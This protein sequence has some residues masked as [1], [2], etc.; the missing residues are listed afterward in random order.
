M[1]LGRITDASIAAVRENA[2]IDRVVA[3]YVTLKKA[4]AGSMKGLCPFHDEKG[5]SFH[6]T[7]SRNYWHCFGCG[8][9]GDVIAFLQKI[10]NLEFVETIERLAERFSIPLDREEVTGRPHR[11]PGL[12]RA[13][14]SR[15]VAANAAAAAFYTDQLATTEAALAQQFLTTRGFDHLAAARF[16]CGYAPDGWDVLIK[17]LT[18]Q[19]FTPEELSTAGLTS[20]SKRGGIDRFRGRLMF[21]IRDQSGDII[22]FGARK[23][24]P[25]DQDKGPKY[26]NTPETP[27]Y[28]KS[29]VLYGLDT[30][31]KPIAKTRRI[32]VV[33]GYT[34]VM[35]CHLSG[36]ETAV[37]TCGTA[38]GE[39]HIRIIRRLLGD[40]G[41][42]GEVIYTFDGDAAGQKAALRAFEMDDHFQTRTLV[43]VEESGMDPCEVRQKHGPAG[44]VALLDARIPLFEFALKAT[45]SEFDLGT[46]EGRTNAVSATSPIL[47]AIKH[48]EMRAQYMLR[49]AR[50][51]GADPEAVRRATRQQTG[52]RS[53]P[54]HEGRTRP[55]EAP[56]AGDRPLEDGHLNPDEAGAP[57][58]PSDPFDRPNPTEYRNATNVLKVMMQSRRFMQLAAAELHRNDLRH[59]TYQAVWDALAAAADD[60]DSATLDEG[61]WVTAVRNKA[62]SPTVVS[63]VTELAVAPAQLRTEFT[64]ENVAKTALML[65]VEACSIR[66]ERIEHAIANPALDA[67]K[68]AEILSALGTTLQRR[69]IAAER[70]NQVDGRNF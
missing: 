53:G 26:L 9:G 48:D 44:I 67:T 13:S 52:T 40:D 23:L 55:Q 18:G 27:L 12:D 49:V 30:A 19:G 68:M 50:W 15:L 32:V 59:P 10:E 42:G 4:G 35:A 70:L 31:R 11:D 63:L 16:G 2:S 22:G 39:E 51:T 61:A 64:Q 69:Q 66:L 1:A 62:T 56:D 58:A 3:D 20:E 60:P 38:F 29:K 7:P 47:A 5:A 54:Q 21:P 6:V 28:K 25:D 57:A 33:E 17:H 45:L 34:D 41:N 46:P 24:L 36:E 14:R 8:E 37:A 43:A 65:V